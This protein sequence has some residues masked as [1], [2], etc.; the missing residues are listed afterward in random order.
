[1]YGDLRY[2]FYAFLDSL[3]NPDATIVLE[4]NP[5]SFRNVNVV[6]LFQGTHS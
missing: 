2:Y 1:M 4:K 5:T 6:W 3:N